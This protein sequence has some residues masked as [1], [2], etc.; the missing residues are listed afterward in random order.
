MEFVFSI[1]AWVSVVLFQAVVQYSVARRRR[2]QVLEAEKAPE[3]NEK[4]NQSPRPKEKQEESCP[5]S[6]SSVREQVLISISGV[7]ADDCKP[8]VDNTTLSL[9]GDEPE[10]FYQLLS[11]TGSE[12]AR[13]STS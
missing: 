1:V 10:E 5:D 9:D 13:V 3:N 6:P 7:P 12:M 2:N 8:M 4:E 11:Q